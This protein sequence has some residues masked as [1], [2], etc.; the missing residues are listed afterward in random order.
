MYSDSARIKYQRCA[1]VYIEHIRC[2][3][4]Q[5]SRPIVVCRYKF[6]DIRNFRLIGHGHWTNRSIRHRE[7]VAASSSNTTKKL[8]WTKMPRTKTPR[9]QTEHIRSICIHFDLLEATDNSYCDRPDSIKQRL[10][11]DV[12]VHRC[13]F[14][15]TKHWTLLIF[16]F[17]FEKTVSNI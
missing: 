15:Q 1:I 10:E 5:F 7:S 14:L 9:T 3:L 12:F 8:F 2:E 6:A 11:P 16:V 13:F 17:Y 4:Y